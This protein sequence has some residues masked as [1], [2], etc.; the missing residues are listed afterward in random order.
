MTTPC[1]Q[2][3]NNR[4]GPVR[5]PAMVVAKRQEAG[6][7]V[8]QVCRFAPGPLL[9]CRCHRHCVS[10]RPTHD[11]SP[12]SAPSTCCITPGFP[13]TLPLTLALSA[14]RPPVCPSLPPFIIAVLP[15]LS[16]LSSFR[17]RFDFSGLLILGFAQFTARYISMRVGQLQAVEA[18][19]I[20][21]TSCEMSQDRTCDLATTC[22]HPRSQ[23]VYQRTD[24]S[25][26]SCTV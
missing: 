5:R 22:P 2:L 25:F 8:V 12:L 24:T 21:V 20:C 14:L 1:Q 3:C 7:R 26:L 10:I 9:L 18:L 13:S 4:R 19:V 11:S 17:L 15:C 16:L 6:A 23:S